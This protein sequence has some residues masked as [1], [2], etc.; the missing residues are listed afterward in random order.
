MNALYL[1]DLAQKT[2][3]GLR[4]RVEPGRSGGGSCYGYA[5]VPGPA[6][7]RWP[8]RARPAP[9]RARPRRRSCGGSSSE[10]AA[11]RSRQGASPT[12]LNAEGVAGPDRARAWGPTHHRRQRRARHRHPQQRALPRPAG[13]EP[14]ALR[15]GPEHRQAGVAAERRRPADRQ[16]R[17]PS[18]GSSTTELWQAVKARQGRMTT[19]GARRRSTGSVQ[20]FWDRRRPRYLFSGLMRCGVCG[21][22]FSKISAAAFRLLDGAQQGHLRQPADH[23]PRRARGH[24]ARRPAPPADGPGA[25][26]ACSWPSSRPSG[27]GCRRA[28]APSWPPSAASS[29]R[30]GGGSTA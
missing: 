15:Q 27:T 2:H 26:R 21:G 16:G 6:G 29:P 9:D 12:R 20:P 7:P 10:Y 25:V 5:V 18:C 23:P 1:K 28:P 30:S 4:G 19:Q 3:R 13:L 22:G 24:R 14:A 11:G 8:A 17:C